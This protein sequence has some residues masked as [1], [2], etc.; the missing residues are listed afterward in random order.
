M[1][2]SIDTSKTHGP[3]PIMPDAF[4]AVQG[5]VAVFTRAKDES[6]IRRRIR[7]QREADVG[8]TQRVM[9]QPGCEE[10]YACIQC[11]T[12]SATCPLSIYMD[13]TPRRVIQLVREGF[14]QDALRSQTIW[15]CASCYACAVQCPQ[16]I[17][18]TD[19]MYTLKREAIAAKLAPR[20]FPIPVLA[21]VFYKMVRSRGRTSELWVVMRL[22]LR[23][24]PLG[25]L[26]MARTGLA[27]LRT[28]RL[29][30]SLERVKARHELQAM[31]PPTEEAN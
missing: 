4:P 24:N 27:L 30:L 18:I 1:P 2:S 12:C 31:L 28:G 7:Y 15:L 16:Q 11:G 13:F 23:T 5:P 19:V 25:M 21:S 3:N 10:L 6:L 9:S 8:W 17:H 29:S 20:R 14:R 26:S 22:M